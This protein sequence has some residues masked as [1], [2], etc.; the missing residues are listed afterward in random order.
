MYKKIGRLLKRLIIL[1]FASTILV[2]I[3]LRFVPVYFTPL[4]FIRTIE[5]ITQGE[6]PKL[7]HHW[8]SASH[9]SNNMKRAVIASEDQRFYNHFG[10]DVKQIQKAVKENDRRKKPR[11][12]STISQQTAK[13]VFLWPQSSW[14]RKGLESYFTLLIE[15]FWTK[16]RILEVYLNSMETGDGIY[17]AESV[18]RDH[19]NTKAENLTKR[20]A[21][22]IAA[23]LPNPRRFNSA[24]P[25]SYIRRRQAKIQRQMRNIR[26]PQE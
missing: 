8:I 5:K 2:V 21:A 6:A 15:V 19:F 16:D 4:M 9:I 26:L 17:G 11:G 25:S 12:A 23:T 22:L 18:A 24:Y 14:V 10:F 7:H 13:N 1:F 20:Q 3:A